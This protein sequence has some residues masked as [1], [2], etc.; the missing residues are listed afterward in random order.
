ML[1][2]LQ[3]RNEIFNA[4]RPQMVCER[5][6]STYNSA[7]MHTDL[8]RYIEANRDDLELM[9]EG[10]LY[11]RDM[12]FDEYLSMMKRNVTCGYEITLRIIGEMFQVPILVVRSDFLWISEKVEP[13]N[14]GIVLVQ[15]AEG[16]FY[17][18]QGKKK[19]NV[20]V[21]P[22]VMSPLSKRS[23]TSTPR[24][25]LHSASGD[26]PFKVELSPV[27]EKE[28]N[29]ENVDT[30]DSVT[31]IPNIKPIEKG[32][33][34]LTDRQVNVSDEK[35]T[36]TKRLGVSGP[37]QKITLPVLDISKSMGGSDFVTVKKMKDKHVIVRLRC[38]KCSRDFFTMGGY[39][40]HLFM[41]HKIRNVKQH[42]P[43]T[44][45]NEEKLFT[46]T[47]PSVISADITPE[48]DVN[49]NTPTILPETKSD[50]SLPDIP[51]PHKAMNVKCPV[52]E[53]DRDPDK[54]YCEY[55]PENFFTPDGVRQHT[56]NVHFREMDRL[57]G[58]MADHV[59]EMQ[60]SQNTNQDKSR[61][62]KKSKP[63]TYV[64]KRNDSV[65]RRKRG[66]ISTDH[67]K[68]DN[69]SDVPVKRRTRSSSK[70]ILEETKRKEEELKNVSQRDTSLEMSKEE[71]VKSYNLRRKDHSN[72]N[73]QKR[74]NETS[75]R[76]S[77]SQVKNEQTDEKSE[78]TAE[79]KE[80]GAKDT[81]PNL[82]SAN[83]DLEAVQF[84]VGNEPA[85]DESLNHDDNGEEVNSQEIDTAQDSAYRTEN[86]TD[87]LN[88][89]S[90]STALDDTQKDPDFNVEQEV[91]KNSDLTITA[92]E[93]NA[94]E[95][96]EHV[97]LTPVVESKSK[98]KN[99]PKKFVQ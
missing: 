30:S 98:K 16:C 13:I 1:Q 92:D 4:I 10:N 58:S 40:T 53:S 33:K 90:E 83:I 95:E 59:K 88:E 50:T 89:R 12:T 93:T 61:G 70:I 43:L 77:K 3:N 67:E 31:L 48:E 27:L 39:N 81:D 65:G 71:F 60:N 68:I 52:P 51:A 34:I 87:T 78:N 36:T 57:F 79:G 22:K 6:G 23:K 72:T 55:C 73:N 9:V 97:Q 91:Q 19:I 44:V 99:T 21:V 69:S 41:D 49:T 14:C 35:K 74:D 15:N 56:A 24:K 54:Y 26:N 17:G 47:E 86:D 7:Q 29:Q 45:P 2:P 80:D 82:N 85:Q 18:M 84:G 75:K 11:D 42:P 38:K 64:Q 32:Q 94:D 62:R 5:Q 46:T 8:L 25:G 20:G 96:E 28:G 37:A 76:K 66:N 63:K